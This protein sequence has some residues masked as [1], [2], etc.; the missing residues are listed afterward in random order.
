MSGPPVVNEVQVGC[1]HLWGVMCVQPRYTR[2]RKEPIRGVY[3]TTKGRNQTC[4][5]FW[6]WK[7]TATRQAKALLAKP[8]QRG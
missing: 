4:G 8:P 6:M 3:M 2:T 7:V 5:G 1:R